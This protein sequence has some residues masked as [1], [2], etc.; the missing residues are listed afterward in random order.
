[1]QTNALGPEV[2]EIISGASESK[3]KPILVCTTGGKYT[4][5]LI[6]KLEEKGVPVYP[7]PHRA[8]RTMRALFD[9]ARG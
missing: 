3:K 2:I 8:M 7:T 4:E 1:M 5:N 6:V 9:H